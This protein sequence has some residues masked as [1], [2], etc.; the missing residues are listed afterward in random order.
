MYLLIGRVV[1]RLGTRR[2]LGL[3]VMWWS[4]AE[5]LHGSVVG[6]KT[7]CLFRGMLA[8][9]EAAIIASGITSAL[10]LVLLYLLLRPIALPFR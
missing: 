7:L 6:I 4:I 1:D 3:A 5:I 2:G 8:I 10:G 9:G